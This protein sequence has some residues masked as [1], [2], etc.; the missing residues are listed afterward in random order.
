MLDEW[1]HDPQLTNVRLDDGSL[2]KGLRDWLAAPHLP[3][4]TT[5]EPDWVAIDPAAA[6]FKV[7]LHNDGVRN[8]ANADN[9]V[10]YGIRT[11]SRLL[12]A[13]DLV[14]SDR[15][16]GWE[17]EVAGYSWDPKAT[18]KG[19][20]EPIKMADHSLDA[21]RY[22]VTTTEALWRPYLEAVAA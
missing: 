8:L 2:S 20:D 7:Q 9:D 15:C 18:E 1:R 12:A 11:V 14:V 16:S 4:P 19:R 5:L 3:G 17:S 22:A 13:G 21:G 6:S 10:S